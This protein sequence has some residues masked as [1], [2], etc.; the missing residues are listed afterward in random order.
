MHFIS[1]INALPQK[2]ITLDTVDHYSLP[3]VAV[4]YALA[5]IGAYV[6]II[7]LQFIRGLPHQRLRTLGIALGAIT[8]GTA[9]W[10]MHFTGML[11]YRMDMQHSYSPM[12]TLLSGLVAVA[13]SFGVY[14]VLT[15]P[16]VP[17]QHMLLAAPLLGIGIAAMH[18][19]GMAA[20]EMKADIYYRSDLFSLSVAI[21]IIVS[22]AALW[23]MHQ[24]ERLN[25]YQR[26]AHILASM[27]MGVAVCG[28]HY[29]GM[30]ATVLVPYA[31]CQFNATTDHLLLV[32]GIT[33]VSSAV[34][35]FAATYMMFTASKKYRLAIQ[36]PLLAV[37]TCLLMGGT[38][39][40]V[41]SYLVRTEMLDT[42]REDRL[43]MGQSIIQEIR[44]NLH[45]A[46]TLATNIA[47]ASQSMP[48]QIEVHKQVIPTIIDSAKMP[49]V[50]AGG[51]YWPEPNKF[52]PGVE[53]RSFF[54]GR[55]A[56]GHLK[57]YED[58]N[59][60]K[61]NGYHHEEWYVPARYKRD[62]RCYWSKSYVDPY[63]FQPMVTCTIPIKYQD[64]FVGVSTIDLKLEGIGLSIQ[65]EVK[66]FSGYG[67]LVDRNNKLI[68]FPDDKLARVG[69]EN[70]DSSEAKE[71]V[72]IETLAKREP[73][74]APIAQQLQNINEPILAREGW[75]ER[76]AIVSSIVANGNHQI[77]PTEA[78]LIE[79]MLEQSEDQ[80][81]E[82]Y[83][84]QEFQ[85]EKAPLVG[86]P[87][88][89]DVYTL[90]TNW[91]LVVVAPRAAVTAHAAAISQKLMLL[92]ALIIL[93][94]LGIFYLFLNKILLRPIRA[95]IR[96]L[97]YANEADLTA[98]LNQ[99]VPNELGEIAYWYNLRSKQL[100]KSREEALQ[101]SELKSDFL[102]N[103]S[104]EL[105]TPLNS[106]IGLSD[107]LRETELTIEQLEMLNIVADSSDNLLAIV[108][109]ILDISKIE[110][111][112][113]EL[114]HIQ[115]YPYM[116]LVRVVD[117]LKPTA[118]KKRLALELHSETVGDEVVLGDPVRFMRIMTNIVGNAIKYTERGRVDVFYSTTVLN[119]ERTLIRVVVRDT[120]IG[121]AK[122]N[123][124]KVFDKFVQADTST[125]RKYGGSG[126]GLA[127]T[128][129]LVE[130]MNGS[131][132]LESE[133]GRGST[134]SITI[135]FTYSADAEGTEEHYGNMKSCG[136]VPAA[137][138]RVLIAEDHLLNQA[139]MKR[140]LPS[141]GIPTF[142][143]VDNGKDA[144]EEALS[145]GY[146]IVLMDCHMPKMSGY[147]ATK[148]IRAT[149]SQQ[150]R[151]PIPIIA[152]T[153]NAMMG[154]REKCLQIGMDEYVSKPIER[155][156]LYQALS[157]WIRFKD[158]TENNADELA[159]PKTAGDSTLEDV[160]QNTE[161]TSTAKTPTSPATLDLSV[162]RTFTDGKRKIEME[163][164][165]IFANESNKHL[166]T[167]RQNV[168]DGVS[169]EWKEAAHAFKGGAAT[170]GAM[171]LRSYCEAA[172]NMLDATIESRALLL[173][174]I[175]QEYA[176][177]Y[178]ELNAL[179][180]I[181]D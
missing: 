89:V 88:Y 12:M 137:R 154:E 60:P 175:E 157:Q 108:N 59:D 9:I 54:W 120:G 113:L 24:V 150:Q 92:S 116:S 82:E 161:E 86:T 3:I 178:A 66:R 25:K 7:L 98:T 94:L 172:Q 16:T 79:R 32:L 136:T 6:A 159:A 14:K 71:F 39:L 106:I 11:A 121:I 131:I 52:T 119:A 95:M 139:F 15:A 55:E 64:E 74:F 99:E 101:A 165:Q 141:M 122:E 117:M 181:E 46:Q 128:K 105:R 125:T 176:R 162:L 173:K 110:S 129:Q 134:F 102:A 23:I 17:V 58:Y 142:T 85:L 147:D 10:S 42:A 21:A 80:L 51:G 72:D 84:H 158:N 26:Q 118:S 151:V 107:L 87:A 90:P 34:F 160:I 167:L 103:M 96:K 61:G 4:S 169:T 13:F 48:K 91:K 2:V 56:N 75:E 43:I 138:A 166:A 140:L 104:H 37:I 57:Y 38:L 114:E 135:P 27:V 133:L 109:D 132:T 124:H 148:A 115:F 168:V 100:I 44:E 53:R 1:D 45:I 171:Q 69:G 77:S 155:S 73:L 156:K 97:S 20:M 111:G 50:V 146:D 127:I 123:I 36:I 68:Y 153:A 145:G 19:T 65:K 152:M 149:E 8:L 170:I 164:A 180:L 177:V 62:D 28:M 143:I 63:S 5:T 22:G 144:V 83:T 41:E 40:A 67:I 33:A 35:A 126:L 179:G 78:E 29:T 31:D 112:S 163:F 130:M 18:Y 81:K 47:S 30:A 49:D 76:N 174:T 70:P 93:L